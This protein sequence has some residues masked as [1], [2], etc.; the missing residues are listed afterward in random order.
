MSF[1]FPA[2]GF[3]AEPI[4]I[5]NMDTDKSLTTTD[6]STID[7]IDFV[8]ELTQTA[9]EYDRLKSFR[10]IVAEMT[11]LRIRSL[12][13]ENRPDEI[14]LLISELGFLLNP[15]FRLLI[16]ILM[17]CPRLTAS[18]CHLISKV[19]RKLKLRNPVIPPPKKPKQ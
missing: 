16:S 9:A 3:T 19:V 12:L 14:H 1:K 2:I 18:T 7:Y 11:S 15:T 17:V 13:F 6:F 5:Y 10:P 8:K 4:A